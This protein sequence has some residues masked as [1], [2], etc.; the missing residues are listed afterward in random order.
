MALDRLGNTIAA[1]DVYLVAGT[2]LRIDGNQVIVVAGENGEH[3][4]RVKSTDVVKVDDAA[5]GGGSVYVV[6]GSTVG[7]SQTSLPLSGGVMPLSDL[8]IPVPHAMTADTVAVSWLS[9]NVPAGDWTLT[10]ERRSAGDTSFLPVATFAVG[11]S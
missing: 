5:G 9:D 10:L 4:V 1:G 3:A 11:T 6:E 2:V 7:T 8:G